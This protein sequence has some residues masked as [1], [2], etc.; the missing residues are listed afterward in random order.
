MTFLRLI[1]YRLGP[2]GQMGVTHVCHPWGAYIASLCY[3]V[4][5]AYGMQ[6]ASA[7]GRMPV[8]WRLP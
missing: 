3:H 5:I 8:Y 4:G 6:M 7:H 1:F 2:W